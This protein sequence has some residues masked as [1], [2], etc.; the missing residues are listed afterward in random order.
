VLHAMG[1]RLMILAWVG[2]PGRKEGV[3]KTHKTAQV[4][5]N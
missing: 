1:R 4:V 5:K 3:V 2:K